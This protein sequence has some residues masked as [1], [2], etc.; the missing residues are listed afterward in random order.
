MAFKMTSLLRGRLGAVLKAKGKYIRGK[1]KLI[2]C[3]PSQ[4]V[5]YIER[6]FVGSMSWET[7][8]GCGLGHKGRHS[9]ES[10]ELDHIM[11]C[12]SFKN[13]ATDKE[14]QKRMNHWSNLRPL[15]WKKNTSDNDKVP[16]GFDW[17]ESK[18]RYVWDEARE[19]EG[20]VNYN[21][22]EPEEEDDEC[23]KPPAKKAKTKKYD[24][25]DH[26]SDDFM[27]DDSDSEDEM[28]YVPVPA[29]A[30]SGR[31]A[32]AKKVVYAQSSDDSESESEFDDEE[33]SD[34]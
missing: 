4:L 3:T 30:R 17:N 26:D 33:D 15:E 23:K 29:R 25:S 11:P 27:E 21:L 12:S 9:Q 24:S 10:W 22:P 8:G 16:K 6:Q 1:K 34:F 14:E 32:A 19:A 28:A 7:H 13:I 31:A 18:G 2:G 5:M 20:K